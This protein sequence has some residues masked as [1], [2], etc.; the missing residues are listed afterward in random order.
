MERQDGSHRI[1]SNKRH[2]KQVLF[3]IIV[4]M[5]FSPIISPHTHT[6]VAR[7]VQ[8]ILLLR[9]LEQINPIN[10]VDVCH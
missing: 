6:R 10:I 2:K 3:D 4:S 7:R 8:R 5:R 1:M 9:L